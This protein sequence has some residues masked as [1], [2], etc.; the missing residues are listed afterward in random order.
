MILFETDTIAVLLVVGTGEFGKISCSINKF[1]VSIYLQ[2]NVQRTNM[3]IAANILFLIT[4]LIVCKSASFRD[5][6]T[7]FFNLYKRSNC[8]LLI[9]LLSPWF[10]RVE[11]LLV[12]T[13]SYNIDVHL[14]INR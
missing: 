3:Y 1:I 8:S 11:L 12:K 10:V 5:F 13:N 2:K 7:S 4:W 6:S 14:N 9:M